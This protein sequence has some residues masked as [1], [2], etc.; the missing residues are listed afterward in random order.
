MTSDQPPGRRRRRLAAIL[1]AALI[2]FLYGMRALT[3]GQPEIWGVAIQGPAGRLRGTFVNPNHLAYFLE[4]S[5]TATAGWVFCAVRGTAEVASDD[6]S[7]RPGAIA[8]S[9]LH[10]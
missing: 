9:G 8:D 1:M 10:D 3:S 7:F 6:P 5:L 4:I 2:Q